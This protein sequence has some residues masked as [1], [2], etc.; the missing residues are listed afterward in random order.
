MTAGRGRSKLKDLERRHV[1]F[2]KQRALIPA[3]EAKGRRH[4]RI[5]YFPTQ[6]TMDIIQRLCDQQATGPIFRNRLGNKWTGF[7][8]KCAF[9][10]LEKVIGKRVKHYDFRRTFITRKIIAGVDSHVVAKLSGHL[11]TAMIDR[12]YS[13]V[14]DDH[15]FMLKMA[16]RDITPSPN[17][18]KPS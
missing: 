7:A 14:A 13:A 8:V 3:S 4:P 6:R 12:H 1:D 17:S 5:I 18:S 2:N 15:E 16:T 11:S 9:A 10:R